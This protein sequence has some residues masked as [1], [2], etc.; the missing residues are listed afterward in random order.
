MKK[1][2]QFVQALTTP[3]RKLLLRELGVSSTRVSHMQQSSHVL[4]STAA[5]IERANAKLRKL[6]PSLP[7][8]LRG[9]LSDDC[10]ACPYFKQRKENV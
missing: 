7:V 2:Q 10:R 5:R 1:L 4:P 9:D 8:V 3:E 6:D